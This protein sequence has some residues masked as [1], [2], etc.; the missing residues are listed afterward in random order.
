M[1]LL[2]ELLNELYSF[3][4][5]HGQGNRDRAS[6]RDWRHEGPSTPVAPRSEIEYWIFTPRGRKHGPFTT[7][8]KAELTLNQRSDLQGSKI[9]AKRVG[10]RV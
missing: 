6:V 10:D 9:V 1:S 3:D 4:D 5:F 8:D 2:R 7:K